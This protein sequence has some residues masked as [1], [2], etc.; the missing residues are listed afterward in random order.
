M[1]STSTILVIE[2]ALLIFFIIL[3]FS[4]G[5]KIF[6]LFAIG[7]LAAIVA[8]MFSITPAISGSV[9]FTIVASLIML[10]LM[11]DTF[12]GGNRS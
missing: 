10:Y 9:P 1:D 8:T 3:S 6:N 2:V 4:N 11:Y 7:M 5:R 12:Y